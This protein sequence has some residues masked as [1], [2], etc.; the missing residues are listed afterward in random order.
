[1]SLENTMKRHTERSTKHW[2][3]IYQMLE[4]HMQ[5]STEELEGNTGPQLPAFLRGFKFSMQYVGVGMWSPSPPPLSYRCVISPHTVHERS[6]KF[7]SYFPSE[8]KIMKV[9]LIQV[10][11]PKSRNLV[12]AKASLWLWP[13]DKPQRKWPSWEAVDNRLEL[14]S[15]ERVESR[16]LVDLRYHFS[17]QP[18]QST[19]KV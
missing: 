7:C 1:M 16:A 17:P 4:K 14:G 5:E 2:F 15:G 6:G 18:H 12:I 11:C 9:R 10:T 8:G 13:W 19:V 3:S